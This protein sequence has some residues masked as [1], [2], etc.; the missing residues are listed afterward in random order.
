MKAYDFGERNPEALSRAALQGIGGTA[1]VAADEA[2]AMN[3]KIAA[4]KMSDPLRPPATIVDLPRNANERTV[5][6]N[7]R[8]RRCLQHR[9]AS[10]H[11]RTM[12]VRCYK[13]GRGKKDLHQRGPAR[14]LKFARLTCLSRSRDGRGLLLHSVALA[15]MRPP[16]ASRGGAD[17]PRS[18]HFTTPD[19][20]AP[21]AAPQSACAH[22]ARLCLRV[23]FLGVCPAI[24]GDHFSPC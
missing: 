17:T 9:R 24:A 13:C 1:K 14:Y 16:T 19:N 6:R 4:G 10:S 8:C 20:Q 12:R 18:L 15:L 5:W 21:I 22:E 11:S 7:T 2:K 3:D 23:R